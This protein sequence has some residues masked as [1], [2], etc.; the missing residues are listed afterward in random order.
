MGS[1]TVMAPCSIL[2]KTKVITGG[3]CMII[4]IRK[5]RKVSPQLV[6]NKTKTVLMIQWV[7]K[8]ISA[9]IN[10]ITREVSGVMVYISILE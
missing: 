10:E 6:L 4:L 5:A 2:L 7:N 8:E 3:K 9:G 1:L